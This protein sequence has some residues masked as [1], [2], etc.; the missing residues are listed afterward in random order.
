MII[1]AKNINK[2]YG[3][4]YAL[5]DFSLGIPKGSS[6]ALLGPNGAGKTT[7][8]KALLDLTP[9]DSGEITIN[10]ISSLSEKSRKGI[11]YLPEK[12]TF[13][14]YYTVEGVLIFYGKMKG[15]NKGLA[16]QIEAVVLKTKITELQQRKVKT[17]SKGQMQRL[18]IACM[19]MGDNDLLLLDEPFTGLDPIGI[20][21]LK[22]ILRGLQVE[23]KTLLINSHILSEVEQICDQ[24]AILNK[25]ELVVE[26]KITELAGDASLEDFFYEKIKS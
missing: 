8:L 16:E 26:G 10:G 18:G 11:G 2:Y 1:E 15:I 4:T 22:E 3:S 5:K 17:L 14:D 24:M 20:K 23:G 7:F 12:F 6:F 9:V 13:F 25:G 19:L 21:D